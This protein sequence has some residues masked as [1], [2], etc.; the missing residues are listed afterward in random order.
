[1]IPYL[2][3]DGTCEEAFRFYARILGGEIVA[4]MPHEGTP[5]ADHVPPEWKGKIIHAR[6]KAGSQELMGSDAPPGMF[7]PMQ[8]FS[9]S[10]HPET[11][12][13]GKRIFDAL[14]EGGTVHMPFQ[15]TFWSTQG[16]GMCV[17]R[18]G[19]PWMVNCP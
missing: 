18:F 19:V 9:V 11:G 10:L 15:P 7:R 14:S 16:F 3:F 8:G 4:M 13:E 12:V 17:D 6:L 5:A 2:H 1:M